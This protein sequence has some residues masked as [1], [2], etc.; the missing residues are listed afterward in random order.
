MKRM[1]LLLVSVLLVT[2][3]GTV[4]LGQLYNEPI[5]PGLP[6]NQFESPIVNGGFGTRELQLNPTAYLHLYR[7]TYYVDE[8]YRFTDFFVPHCGYGL[9]QFTS[10]ASAI[11]TA[12]TYQGW[13]F[14]SN[15]GLATA[16][17]TPTAG[18]DISC[19]AMASGMGAVVFPGNVP[20]FNVGTTQPSVVEIRFALPTFTSTLGAAF[21]GLSSAVSSTLSSSPAW[22]TTATTFGPAQVIGVFVTGSSGTTT[23]Y[24]GYAYYAATN[25]AAVIA[26]TSVSVSQSDTLRVRIDAT[27]SGAVILSYKQND[28]GWKTLATFSGSPFTSP[29]QPMLQVA[30]QADASVI[31]MR[32]RYVAGQIIKP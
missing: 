13:V 2:V 30:K 20:V 21:V 12:S 23:P 15:S 25:S 26:V 3:L 19:A 11:Y 8:A 32:V 5:V 24:L 14:Y 6:T 4:A 31:D 29:L 7:G 22:S 16:T 1:A 17:V 18:L 27:N 9:T 10:S 28:A